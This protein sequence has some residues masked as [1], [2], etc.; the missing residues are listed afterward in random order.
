MDVALGRMTDLALDE[1]L[2]GMFALRAS[3]SLRKRCD[4][5]ESER[6]RIGLDVGAEMDVGDE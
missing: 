6:L 5:P 2:M 1:V 3:D 4:A